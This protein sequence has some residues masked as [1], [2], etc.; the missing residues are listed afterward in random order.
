[1]RS[2]QS[3]WELSGKFEGD[4]ALPEDAEDQLRNGLTSPSTRWPNRTVPY[5]INDVFSEYPVDICA[6]VPRYK[7]ICGTWRSISSIVKNAFRK[8]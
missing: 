1:V 2:K 3:A 6:Q 7:G 5:V 4:I 8:K